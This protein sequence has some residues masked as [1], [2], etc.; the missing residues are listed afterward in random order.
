MER[1][2]DSLEK[3][4]EHDRKCAREEKDKAWAE[5]WRRQKR[6]MDIVLTAYAVA[7]ATYIVLAAT[8]HLHHH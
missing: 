1:R 3:S 4:V 7:I 6:L 2:I 8:G 5:K